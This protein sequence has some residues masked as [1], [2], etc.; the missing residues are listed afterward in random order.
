MDPVAFVHLRRYLAALGWRDGETVLLDEHHAQGDAGAVP[1]L[2][3]AIASSVPAVVV[4][5]GI[6]EARAVMAATAVPVVFLQVVDPVRLGVV[7]SFARPGGNVTGVAA[8]GEMLWGKRIEILRELL[9]ARRT[10]LAVLSN[11]ANPSHGRNLADIA[12]HAPRYGFV[13]DTFPIGRLDGLDTVLASAAGHDAML[14]PHDF[15]LFPNRRGVV[16]FAAAAQL[17]AIY[18]NRFSPMVGGMASYG[19]DLRDNYRQGAIYVDRILRGA[20]PS[21]LPVVQPTR[22]ELVANVAAVTALGLSIPVSL[23]A[24]ADEVFE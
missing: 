18:E 7:A 8:S 2:A 4:V 16:A 5:T 9:P 6:T 3:D 24:R 15:V 22:V 13:P 1:R 11:S 12:M 23:L 21:D 19:A 17:P 14:V 20:H 10:R